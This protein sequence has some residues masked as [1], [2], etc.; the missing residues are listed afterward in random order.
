[1]LFWD[2][3]QAGVHIRVSCRIDLNYPQFLGV[4][5]QGL[6]LQEQLK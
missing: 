2:V 1:M 4:Y 3:R 6:L 5:L